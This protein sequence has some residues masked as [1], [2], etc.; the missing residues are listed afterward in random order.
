M[1]NRLR[2]TRT[3]DNQAEKQEFEKAKK[4]SEEARAYARQSIKTAREDMT[5]LED[6]I[7][8]IWSARRTDRQEQ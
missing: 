6:A 8:P 1:V 5:W 2:S 7:I 4:D 3:Q